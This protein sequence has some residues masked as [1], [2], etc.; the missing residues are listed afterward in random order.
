MLRIAKPSIRLGSDEQVAGKNCPAS[1]QEDEKYAS[2]IRMI[3]PPVTI[4]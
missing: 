1:S 3:C 4:G 2:T